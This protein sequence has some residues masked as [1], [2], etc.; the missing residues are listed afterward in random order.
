MKKQDDFFKTQIRIPPDVYSAVKD[1]A[2]DN[3]R[4]INAEMIELFLI[5]LGRKDLP[6]TASELRSIMR[7]ELDNR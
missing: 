7:E 3:G 5:G 1:A 2:I 6:V 4:S